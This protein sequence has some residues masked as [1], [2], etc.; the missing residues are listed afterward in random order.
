MKRPINSLSINIAD[1]VLKINSEID[2]KRFTDL[3]FYQDFIV[4]KNSHYHCQLDLKTSLPY[5]SPLDN[6]IFNPAG[7]WRLAKL[8]GRNILQLDLNSKDSRPEEVIVFNADYTQGIIYKKHILELFRRFIDQ[9]ILINLLSPKR[10]FL[11]HASG[12]IWQSKGLVFVGPSGA[13]KSTLIKLFR[14]EVG[15]QDILNDDR[16][17]IRNYRKNWFVFGTPWHGEVPITS[18]SKAELKA[19]FFIRQSKKNYLKRLSYADAYQRLIVCGLMPFWNKH[20]VLNVLHTF[21]ILPQRIPT[22]EMGFLPDRSIVDL[23]K[24]AV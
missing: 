12:L 7:N 3:D 2:L 11:L 14:Q 22:F 23:I 1:I 16:I 13:G 20:S 5:F 9:F 24:T 18:S 8:D 19:I 4:K 21:S 6:C 10:G 17:A 15:K